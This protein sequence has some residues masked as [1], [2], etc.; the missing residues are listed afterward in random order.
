MQFETEWSYT[1]A[2]GAGHIMVVV[3]FFFFPV[4]SYHFLNKKK[5]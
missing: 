5:H 1:L 2:R 4:T 3:F